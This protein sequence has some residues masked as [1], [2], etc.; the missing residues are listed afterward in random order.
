F[1]GVGFADP[2]LNLLLGRLRSTSGAGQKQHYWIVRSSK[3]DERRAYWD[4][5]RA[6]DL[7]RYGIHALAVDSYEEIPE[8]LGEVA[9][10]CT[11]E[12]RAKT[13]FISGSLDENTPNLNLVRDTA[14]Y[15][16]S[17]LCNAGF[18]IATGMGAGLGDYTVSA[19]Y[20]CLV[21]PGRP[22]RLEQLTIHT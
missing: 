1:L 9:E 17:K 10:R 4:R 14:T 6:D 5:L 3:A 12:R 11:V 21:Q 19:A 15:L 7:Q 20:D 8:L 22:S 16:V 2:N 13:V 18:R